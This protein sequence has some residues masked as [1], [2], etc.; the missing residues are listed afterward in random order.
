[1]ELL[2]F[3]VEDRC[4]KETKKAGLRSQTGLAEEVRAD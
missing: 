2:F 3:F 4:K 1:M